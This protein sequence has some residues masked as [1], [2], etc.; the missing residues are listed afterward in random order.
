MQLTKEGFTLAIS[1]P[2]LRRSTTQIGVSFRGTSGHAINLTLDELRQT[3]D[4]LTHI[5]DAPRTQIDIKIYATDEKGSCEEIIDLY[6][7]EENGVHDWSGQGHNKTFLLEVYIAETCIFRN[8]V[9][10]N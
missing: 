2:N 8:S 6:W 3:R 1:A 5:L 7:F 4:A 9:A 10:T